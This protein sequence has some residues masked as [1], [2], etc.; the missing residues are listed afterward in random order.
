MKCHVMVSGKDQCFAVDLQ[1][2]GFELKTLP[3]LADYWQVSSRFWDLCSVLPQLYCFNFRREYVSVNYSLFH[4][5]QERSREWPPSK[6]TE[7]SFSINKEFAQLSPQFRE[8]QNVSLKLI[9]V[10]LSLSHTHI[11]TFSC[12]WNNST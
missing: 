5:Q 7:P 2:C 6:C 12:L 1:R 10:S 4:L 11:H 9:W 8:K 3:F